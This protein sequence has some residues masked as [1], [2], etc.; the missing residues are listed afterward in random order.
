MTKPNAL[1]IRCGTHKGD[2]EETCGH[3]Q[4]APSSDLEM[5]KALILSTH[6]DHGR[7]TAILEAIG[8]ELSHGVEFRYD[9]V[10][11]QEALEDVRGRALARKSPLAIDVILWVGPVILLAA[12]LWLLPRVF[13]R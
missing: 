4:F 8:R 9:P 12:A 5:A 7:S 3:C 11:L 2:A 10:E 1:C 6:R 13:G